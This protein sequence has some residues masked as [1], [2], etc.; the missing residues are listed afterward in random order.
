MPIHKLNSQ[1]SEHATLVDLTCD[2]DGII[3]KFV[4]LKDIKETLELHHFSPK[5]PYYLAFFMI[6]AYQEVMGNF[7]NLFGTLNEAHVII[8][9]E[10]YLIKKIITGSNLGDVL[11]LARYDKSFLW[12][13]FQKQLHEQV[14]VGRLTEAEA[15]ELHSEYEKKITNYTYLG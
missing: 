7:H 12:E 3:D 6:G 9:R 2:S 14:K 11:A 4:D 10:N 13:N 15:A 5:D 8:N 1:P